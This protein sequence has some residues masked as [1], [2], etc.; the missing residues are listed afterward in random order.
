MAAPQTGPCA[1]WITADDVFDCRPCSSIA[2]G[3]QDATLAASVVDVASDLLWRLSGRKYPGTCTDTVRPC[4]R[5][6]AGGAPGWWSWAS[7]TW[8]SCSCQSPDVRACGCSRLDAIRLGVDYPVLSITTVKV[9]GVT[10]VD[11]SDYRLDDSAW[12]TRI[13][14]E[15]WPCCQDLTLADTELDTFSVEFSYGR[16]PSAPAVAA[17]K[18]LACELYRLCATGTCNLP[19]RIRTISR[20]G[21]EVGFIDPMDFLAEGKTGLY[22]VDLFLSA[23]RHDAAHRGTVVVNPDV[24]ARVVRPG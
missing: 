6:S 7:P 1:D 11:G 23:E 2:A 8:G 21:V 3:D 13:D 22:Q 14:G 18:A 10:L 20:Q 16:V 12:L 9:D 24:H 5:R 19:Q 4:A 15:G 17:A